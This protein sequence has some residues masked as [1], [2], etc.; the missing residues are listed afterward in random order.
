MV[1]VHVR[2][3]DETKPALAAELNGFYPE[4]VFVEI[5]GRSVRLE[6]SRLVSP[7][8]PSGRGVA[9]MIVVRNTWGI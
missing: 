6:R 7:F 9:M 8:K 2:V 3:D 4:Q 5:D 1:Y